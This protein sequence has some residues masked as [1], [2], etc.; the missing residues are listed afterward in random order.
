MGMKSILNEDGSDSDPYTSSKA[1]SI[2]SESS[3]NGSQSQEIIFN[4]GTYIAFV[5][6]SD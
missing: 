2:L 4:K 1:R 6:P 3:D 5:D